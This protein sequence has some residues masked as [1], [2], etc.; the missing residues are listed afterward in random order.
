MIMVLFLGSFA[1]EVT[2]LDQIISVSIAR[3][4]SF[5]SAENHTSLR[6]R[7]FLFM[8]GVE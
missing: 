6:I 4:L 5:I 8:R 2:L 7:K 3:M 1:R